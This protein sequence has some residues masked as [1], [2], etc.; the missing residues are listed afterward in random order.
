LP[1]EII[2]CLGGQDARF[3]LENGEKLLSPYFETIA[4]RDYEDRLVFTELS[5][6]LNY[7]LSEHEIA[8][9]MPLSRLGEFVQH[10][11]RALA[12]SGQ[13]SVTVRKGIFVGQKRHN[14][15]SK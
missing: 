8:W 10:V 2:Q 3:G 4:R 12:R 6:V 7:V 13:I 5:P 11:K 15:R 9:S 1:G 14:I